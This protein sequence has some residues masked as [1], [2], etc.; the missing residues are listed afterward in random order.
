[1]EM[2]WS[3][4]MVNKTSCR[5]GKRRKTSTWTFAAMKMGQ[6]NIVQTEIKRKLRRNIYVVI[7]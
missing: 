6:R 7:C 5:G 2:R 3:R 4:E 1:M